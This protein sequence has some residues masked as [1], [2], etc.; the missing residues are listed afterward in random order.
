MELDVS[1]TEKSYPTFHG[2][3]HELLAYVDPL[4][5]VYLD[6][7][8][9]AHRLWDTD[10]DP[11]RNYVRKN[12]GENVEP[13]V[14]EDHQEFIDELYKLVGIMGL[15]MI[16]KV[17][18]S[19][20][21]LKGV[22]QVWFNQWKEERVV[23][24]GLFDWE[25]FKGVFLDRFFPLEMRKE[26]VLEFI[27]LQQGNISVKEYALKFTQLAKSGGQ[28][29]PQFREKFFGQR[30]SNSPSPKLN[31]DRMPNPKPQGG[32]GNRSSI[33]ACQGVDCPL[34]AS[35]GKDCRE[36]Q[37]ISYGRGAPH[38]NRFYA[39]QTRHDHEDSSDVVAELK[40]LK[41][42][43]KD[44]LDKVFIRPSILPWG[45]PVL[46]V[47]KKDGSLRIYID[48][49]QLSKVTIK[50]KYPIPRIDN[51]FDR[52]QGA[53]YFSKINLWSG[54]HQLRVKENDIPKMAFRTRYDHYEFL[55]MSFR[56]TNALTKLM[57]LL[58]RFFK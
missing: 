28:G 9:L 32:G 41:D 27:N 15:S 12:A 11:Q 17:D 39:L 1:H 16:E 34:Q 50:N 57:D 58:N 6:N 21:Q 29:R 56:L 2:K 37:P 48:Y 23:D 36:A 38:Q 8:M 19:A 10:M 7:P 42:Y 52:L 53:S 49:R 51:L 43:F 45:A 22:S 54:Y 5:N 55:V 25:K 40:E 4:A 14:E 44:F 18:L 47:R 13:E 30:S 3:D 20:Y 35:K 46:F 33:P 24:E 26:N 31:K